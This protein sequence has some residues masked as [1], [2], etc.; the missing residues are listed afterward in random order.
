[1]RTRSLHW[2]GMTT[3]LLFITVRQIW[4]SG[5]CCCVV[6]CFLQEDDCPSEGQVL[7]TSHRKRH[8]E[9]VLSLLAKQHQEPVVSQKTVCHPEVFPWEKGFIEHDWSVL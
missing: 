3:E 9:A 2:R 6:F 5:K 1:M 8:T 4:F 7:R